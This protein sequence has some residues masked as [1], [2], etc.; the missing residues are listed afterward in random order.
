M[1]SKH[2]MSKTLQFHLL[3]TLFQALT[4]VFEKDKHADRVIDKYLRA[5]PKWSPAERTLL[6]E[7]IY[8]ITRHKRLFEFQTESEDLWKLI[9]AYF[10]QKGFKLLPR[11]EYKGVE[12]E[13]LKARA[14]LTKPP[15]I[16]HSFPDWLHELGEKEFGKDWPAL[17]KSLNV[18]PEIFLRVNT[19]K[20]DTQK[21]IAELKKDDIKGDALKSAAFVLPNALQLKE[22]RNVFSTQ[23]FKQGDFEMQDAAS[24]LVAPLLDVQP[25][26]PVV[27]PAKEPPTGGT[28]KCF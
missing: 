4:E 8:E 7:G 24:Q 22:R 19:L 17:M 6:A 26:G 11:R 14:A 12:L 23:A 18:P 3:N 13:L 20:T 5:N 9:A 28:P 16:E 27:H 2:S 25:A 10:L 21:L 1:L 15:A